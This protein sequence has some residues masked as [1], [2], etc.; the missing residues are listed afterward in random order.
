[1]PPLIRVLWR[2]RA[3][4]ARRMMGGP[5]P[6]TGSMNSVFRPEIAFV[7]GGNMASALIG[8]LLKGGRIP[9]TVLVI[10]PDDRQRPRLALQFGV[11][12]L[13]AA[14]GHLDGVPLVVWAVKP[15]SFA[16]AVRPCA[17]F[18][19]AALQLSVMAG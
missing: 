17:P 19:G 15:Q 9:A 8:G 2:V 16:A 14:D 18:V 4:P 3:M 10:E 1:M 6:Y 7:G 13:P 5:R 11:L 12:A